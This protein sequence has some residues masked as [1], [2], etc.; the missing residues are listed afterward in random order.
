MK[1]NVGV[2]LGK[3]GNRARTWFLALVSRALSTVSLK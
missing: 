1:R 2:K 3:V